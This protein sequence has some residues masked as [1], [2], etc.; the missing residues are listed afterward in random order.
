MAHLRVSPSARE[1]RRVGSLA[2]K[3]ILVIG[4]GKGIGCSVCQQFAAQGATLAA[5]DITPINL[6]TT[7]ESVQNAGGTIRT[8]VSDITTKMPV[9]GLLNQVL[10]DL[11]Q[12]DILVNCAEVEP[13]K[14]LL[15]MDECD[16]RRTLE[17]NLN[18]AFLLTQS[19]ARIMK[20]N[21]AG[22]RNGII[23]HAG[24]RAKGMDGHSA[25]LVSKSALE[26]LVQQAKKELAIFG[27]HVHLIHTVEEALEVCT[28]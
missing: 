8:Y 17:V 24:Q 7:A 2:G 19:A 25:Y 27:I 6:D 20:E 3:V 26:V 23:L 1:A 18:G 22:T 11:G 4:A 13:E 12:I 5:V 14:T 16:W 28:A 9:Q 21:K 15:E 10:D